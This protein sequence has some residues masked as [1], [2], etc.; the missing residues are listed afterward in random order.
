MLRELIPNYVYMHF[1]ALMIATMT[2]RL[3]ETDIQNM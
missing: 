1:V 2:A 3:F